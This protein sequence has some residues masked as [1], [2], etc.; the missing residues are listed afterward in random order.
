MAK[1]SKEQLYGLIE[2]GIVTFTGLLDKNGEVINEK[3]LDTE[4]LLSKGLITHIHLLNIPIGTPKKPNSNQE[5]S[6]KE[7]GKES[8]KE[9]GK[10]NVIPGP[11]NKVESTEEYEESAPIAGGI[12]VESENGENEEDKKEEKVKPGVISEEKEEK[13]EEN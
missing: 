2:K 3:Y 13:S 12:Q 1:I 11:I 9:T 6:S 8:S 4:Y 5:E 10:E 7:I